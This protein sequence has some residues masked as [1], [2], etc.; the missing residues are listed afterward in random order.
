ML[1]AMSEDDEGREKMKK[2]E[3]E[4]NERLARDVERRAKEDSDR[5]KNQG[6]G[7]GGRIPTMVGTPHQA[8]RGVRQTMRAMRILVRRR[9]RKAQPKMSRREE[10]QK[11]MPKETRANKT[12]VREAG[13]RESYIGLKP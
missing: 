4:I 7:K 6:G 3:E 1:K 9:L 8:A 13:R 10:K 11:G 5:E 12:Q 2:R